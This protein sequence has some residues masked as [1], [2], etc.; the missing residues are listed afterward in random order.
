MFLMERVGFHLA[1]EVITYELQRRD[2]PS[3]PIKHVAFRRADPR[4][5]EDLEVLRMIDER[6]F[7]WLWRNSRLE[8]VEYG[9]DAGV[10]MFV[11]YWR[12]SPVSYIGVTSYLLAAN[13]DWR[14]KFGATVPKRWTTA[15]MSA[16]SDTISNSIQ[17]IEGSICYLPLGAAVSAKL[18]MVLKRDDKG[19]N[20]TANARLIVPVRADSV[21]NAT[22][23]V[24]I[25]N[26]AKK[27]WK[28][29]LRIKP[30][31][32]D[33]VRCEEVTFKIE[34]DSLAN[35]LLA[36]GVVKKHLV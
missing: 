11:G 30:D 4:L 33:V 22:P 20:V 24:K 28:Q 6:A 19:K 34:Q 16:S 5:A 1:E 35:L 21:E 3:A 10:E 18:S 13:A 17:A 29:S 12:D 36:V 8:F 32:R 23:L 25:E 2:S 31:S 15:S 27:V 14:G 7:P 9:A 26:V